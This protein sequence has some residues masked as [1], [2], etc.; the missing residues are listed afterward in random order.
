[1]IRE[2]KKCHRGSSTSAQPLEAGTEFP[3][4]FTFLVTAKFEDIEDSM[5]RVQAER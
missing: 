1:M 2:I 4:C 3:S 5:K